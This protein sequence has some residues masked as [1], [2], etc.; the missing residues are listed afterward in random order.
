MAPPRP[1]LEKQYMSS[2][3]KPKNEIAEPKP[4]ASILLI[5]PTNQILLLHRVRTS[6]SFASAH[7]FPGGNLSASQDGEIP[8]LKDEGRHVDGSAYRIG[9][10]RET[11]EESGI[12]LAKKEDGSLL[13]VEEDIREKAR[14]D[15]HAG[16]LK[17][18]DWV[19]SLGG[20]IDSDALHP[21]TRW[22]T[23]PNLPKRFTTQMYIYFLPLTQTSAQNIISA[24]IVPTPT[25]DGGVEH[26][27]ALFA[28][29]WDW[30]NQATK[31][32]VMLFPP[33][34]YLMH[35]LS[36]FLIPSPTPLS[37]QE[38]QKQRDAVLGFLQGDGDGKGVKW[39]D[40][41]MSPV[42]L[43]MRKS[44]G[45]SVLS[46]EKPGPELVGSGRAG[47]AKRVV[48]V[49]F[50]KEGPRDVEVRWRKEVLDEEKREKL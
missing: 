42:G 7:V 23:P 26:T 35:L 11:F 46:L 47:D 19:K 16:K 15:I 4:S 28:S 36:P 10:I 40:K 25:S 50:S 44:D 27:A 48:L 1:E 17:F 22:I 29:C 33:Q 13:E 14:K 18:Q 24:Y 30:L 45:R 21:F 32:E 37:T 43:L 5:S 34:Y 9:A 38:L 20:V 12:L 39:A 41:V 6:S 2:N 31:G 8:G 3:S 49:K